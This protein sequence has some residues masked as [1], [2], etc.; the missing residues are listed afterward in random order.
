MRV[1]TGHC[2]CL[3]KT[4]NF[5]NNG[6]TNQVIATITPSNEYD[7]AAQSSPIAVNPTTNKIYEADING[8]FVID[9]SSNSVKEITL[10]GTSLGW[11]DLAINTNTNTIY[12]DGVGSNGGGPSP[13]AV[14]NGTTDSYVTTFYSMV[15]L[16][17]A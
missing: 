16:E 1:S 14:V 8:L 5:C 11:D 7:H 6:T 4:D 12:V 9:G 2:S 10:Y 13:I 3:C 15:I 17:L